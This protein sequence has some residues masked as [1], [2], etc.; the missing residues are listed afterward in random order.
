[1]NSSLQA[2]FFV[3]RSCAEDEVELCQQSM[4]TMQLVE[5]GYAVRRLPIDMNRG[6]ELD[7]GAILIDYDETASERKRG[8]PRGQS[9]VHNVFGF[10]AGLFSSIIPLGKSD[11]VTLEI[12]HEPI[13]LAEK[14]GGFGAAKTCPPQKPSLGGSQEQQYSDCDCCFPFSCRCCFSALPCFAVLLRL[15]RV[16]AEWRKLGFSADSLHLAMNAPRRDYRGTL[17]ECFVTRAVCGSTGV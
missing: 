13:C 1:M 16:V 17:T 8:H 4:K 15:M 3:T 14:V 5:D 7:V 12:R 10:A 9:I 6:R 11:N 2:I